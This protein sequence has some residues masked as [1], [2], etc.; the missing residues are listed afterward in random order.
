MFFSKCIHI[1]TLS[2]NEIYLALTNQMFNFVNF[3]N[4]LFSE[5]EQTLNTHFCALVNLGENFFPV[6]RY[7]YITNS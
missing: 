7:S 4:N 6:Y 3:S 2:G 5:A 1:L